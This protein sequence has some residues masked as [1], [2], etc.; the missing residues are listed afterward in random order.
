[1][2]QEILAP[3]GL[4]DSGCLLGDKDLFDAEQEDEDEVEEESLDAIRSAVKQKAKKQKV[5][6][7]DLSGNRGFN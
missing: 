4:N 6:S 5:G 3:A 7:I 1:M 2:F